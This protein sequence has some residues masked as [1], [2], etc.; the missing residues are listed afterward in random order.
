MMKDADVAED[1]RCCKVVVE[2]YVVDTDDNE[3]VEVEVEVEVEYV[4]DDN[5]YSEE[6]YDDDEDLIFEDD[7]NNIQWIER[8]SNTKAYDIIHTL[9]NSRK[10]H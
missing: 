7:T 10:E 5:D 9:R 2:V 6:D 1:G 8:E 4:T 3:K